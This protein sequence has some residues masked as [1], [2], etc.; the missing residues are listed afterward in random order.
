[1]SALRDGKSDIVF[2]NPRLNGPVIYQPVES[3]RPPS[4]SLQLLISSPTPD[5]KQNQEQYNISKS[6]PNPFLIRSNSKI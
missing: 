3:K 2:G 6:I 4:Y 1:M 5:I